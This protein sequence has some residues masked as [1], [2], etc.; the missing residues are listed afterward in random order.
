MYVCCW[1]MYIYAKHFLS[2]I[3]LV[4]CTIIIV[5][6]DNVYFIFY[7]H[8]SY[9]LAPSAPFNVSLTNATTNSV[10]VEW[11]KPVYPNGII[12]FFIVSLSDGDIMF[13]SNTTDQRATF[14]N[15]SP[16]WMYTVIVSAYTNTLGNSSS[17]TV[18]TLGGLSTLSC[19]YVRILFTW[20][21]TCCI[22]VPTY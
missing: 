5:Y 3:S 15:L 22:Y 13:T 21:H 6:A 14:S 4:L 8:I 10:T 7:A 12:H 1:H 16:V 20:L 19:T 9:I 17:I 11:N 18:W 2:I